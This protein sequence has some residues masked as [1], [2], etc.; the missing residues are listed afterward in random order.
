[1]R[2]KNGWFGEWVIGNFKIVY[3]D[4]KPKDEEK[5]TVWNI[6]LNIKDYNNTMAPE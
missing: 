3:S 6:L 5:M 1:M 2:Q 4:W